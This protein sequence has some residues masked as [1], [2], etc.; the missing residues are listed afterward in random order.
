MMEQVYAKN[1]FGVKS[2]YDLD[3]VQKS[4]DGKKIV[5]KTWNGSLAKMKLDENN[6][7]FIVDM[8]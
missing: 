4:N 8:E 1:F 2:Y 5:I 7:C 3:V 6:E